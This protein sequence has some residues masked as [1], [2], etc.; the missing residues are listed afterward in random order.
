[1]N[2]QDRNVKESSST[3]GARLPLPAGKFLGLA[4][5]ISADAL[6]GSRFLRGYCVLQ[7]PRTR[8]CSGGK[9]DVDEHKARS[10][11]TLPLLFPFSGRACFSKEN[12]R[13][14]STSPQILKPPG[15]AIHFTRCGANSYRKVPNKWIDAE[16]HEQNLTCDGAADR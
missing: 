4:K 11:H 13:R 12:R 16:E 9:C 8:M 15:Y 14:R 5:F 6:Q 7:K 1:M 10:L 2:G 3:N